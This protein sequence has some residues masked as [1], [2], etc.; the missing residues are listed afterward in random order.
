MPITDHERL[1]ALCASCGIALDYHDIRGQRHEPGVDVK[2]SLLAALRLPVNSDDDIRHNLEQ[3]ESRKW[4]QIVAPAVVCRQN[5]LPIRLT[6]TLNS[7][8]IDSAISW[9]LNPESGQHQHGEW[10]I[11]ALDAV[12]EA[13]VEGTRLMRFEVTLPGLTEFGYHHLVIKAGDGGEAQTTLIV[14]PETCY[15]PPELAD[16]K[17]IWGISLQLFSLRSKRNWGIGDF[18]DLHSVI[19][20]FAPLGISVLGLNPLHAL[21]S[22][23]PENA[24]PYSP[25]SRD[26]LN[27]VYLDVEAIDEFM[28]DAEIKQRVKKREFQARLR[29]LRELE[30]IDYPEV[31][32]LKLQVLESL[33]EAFK[34]QHQ[35][36]DSTRI[37]A[38]RQ[39]QQKGGED[40]FYFAL[41]EALQASFHRQDADIDQWQK[42][43][44]AYR[45][46]ESETVTRWADEHADEIAFHQYLQWNAEQQLSMNH[47]NCKRHGMCIGIYRDLAVGDAK[48]SARCWAEQGD[49]ALGIGIGAP[50][51]DFNSNG[52]N[53]ALPPLKPQA[54]R[55]QAYRP[56]IK[57]LRA[58]MRHAGALRIDHIMG[59]MRLFWVPPDYSPEE[60]SYISYPFENLLAIL[61]LESQRHHCLIIGEDLGTV[62]DEVRHALYTHKMLSF[63]ILNFEKDWHHGTMRPPREYPRHS[64]CTSG[65]H[66]L[67]T[68]RGFWQGAD[69]DLREQLD[70]Y[71]SDES[72]EQQRQIRQQD[73]LEILTAL[74]REN[75]IASEAID[76]TSADKDLSGELAQTI[77]RYLARSRSMLLMVQLEDLLLET[78]Q[79]NVPGTID[80]YPN[81]RGKL[82]LNLEDWQE[83]VDVEGF[84]RVINAERDA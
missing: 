12:D 48:S 7:S 73:R 3:V 22:H 17:K 45:D 82:T 50:P 41:F 76:E 84:A 43:P 67:P 32:R 28:Q 59:L 61:A 20:M 16:G 40:L 83:Q 57:T 42:W 54:L 51:D 30:L 31:W 62:P 10:K 29:V 27:P 58:N 80:E 15:Q 9:A 53:W 74:A 1:D 35:D 18:T 38:F 64:L 24:S 55:N 78:R 72:G 60:G 4:R 25:S 71:P 8:Q 66:D 52:Q 37:N 11:N 26:F 44:E 5:D 34:R 21:F 39:F 77:Q 13:D 2:R 19:E 47:E 6:L 49:Y 56:F 81:W 33:Y 69:L 23:L 79:V 68:L 70:L 65:S 36:T 46:P 75:L 14:A 63:R